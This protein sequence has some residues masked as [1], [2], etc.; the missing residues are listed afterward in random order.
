[1]NVWKRKIGVLMVATIVTG[2]LTSCGGSTSGVP[3]LSETVPVSGGVH[4]LTAVSNNAVPGDNETSTTIQVTPAG[5]TQPI[6]VVIPPHVVVRV[7]DHLAI[8]PDDQEILSGLTTDNRN[9]GDIYV[10][11]SKTTSHVINGRIQPPIGLPAG[12]FVLRAEGPLTVRQG[13]SALTFQSFVMN[14]DCDGVQMSLPI[15]FIGRL[16]G[17]GSNNWTNSVTATFAS[18]YQTGTATLKVTHR[19]GTLSRTTP[20]SNGVATFIDYSLDGQSIIPSEGV[21]SITFTHYKTN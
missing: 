13:T 20:L 14:F 21:D 15:D 11:N 8:I 6:D 9:P 10:N 17:N 16:P 7:G 1:M 4:T 19:N 5:S 18:H 3:P 2:V 12:R